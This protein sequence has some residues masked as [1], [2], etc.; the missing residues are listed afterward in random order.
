LKGVL[1]EAR[2]DRYEDMQALVFSLWEGEQPP[3]VVLVSAA[4]ITVEESLPEREDRTRPQGADGGEMQLTQ[5]DL[6][7]EGLTQADAGE[8]AGAV[9]ALTAGVLDLLQTFLSEDGLAES[10]LV[11]VTEGALAL[12][13]EAPSLLQGALPGLVRSARSEHPGRFALLDVGVAGDVQ[14]S[15]LEVVLS[16]DEP[17]LVLRGGVLHAPRLTRAQLPPLDDASGSCSFDPGGTVL[18]TGGTGG[19]GALLARHLVARHGARHLLLISRSGPRAQ[20]AK[21]LEAELKER[22][23]KA[24]I[25]ACD[26]TDRQA[27]AKLIASI[28][29]THPLTAVVHTAGI[30]DDG[31]ITSLDQERLTAVMVPKVDAAINLHLLTQNHDLTH[32]VLYSSIASTWGAPG[33]GN[34]SAANSFLDTLAAHR[35]ANGL[36]ALSLAWGAWERTS[37]ITRALSEQDRQ[38]FARQGMASLADEQGLELFDLATTTDKPL[39]IAARLQMSTLR[40]QGRTGMLPHLLHALVRVTPRRSTELSG[41]LAA[42]LSTLPQTEWETTIRETVRRHVAAV[43][44]HTNPQEIDTTANFLE[45]GLDSLAALELRDR[46]N[47]DTGLRLPAILAMDY[48]TIA[49]LAGYLLTRFSSIS[50]KVDDDKHS[51][52]EIRHVLSAV[53]VDRVRES[54]LLESLLELS[55]MQDTESQSIT[56]DDLALDQ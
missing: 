14:L 16:N 7:R 34:Y 3:E 44:G 49:A 46:L 21:E 35:H 12:E 26:A 24:R 54:G 45:L 1:D 4:A 40:T 22:G 41:A 37:G 31:I 17:E 15:S 28:S 13:G 11:L 47:T 2:V 18:I 20:G 43:L 5:V 48:P 39:L 50:P 52:D 9:R 25:V 29:E 6:A 42:K 33:Q 56:S 55:E 38:R 32:F 36:P 53:S 23:A 51:E 10:K 19:L 27:L 30:V 8:L